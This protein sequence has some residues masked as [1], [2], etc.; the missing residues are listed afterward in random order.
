MNSKRK[1][2]IIITM[3]VF[4]FIFLRVMNTLYYNELSKDG[5]SKEVE[6]TVEIN[7]DGEVNV[8]KDK[9]ETISNF[10]DED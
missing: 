7:N 8:D 2:L 10:I 4:A 9:T 6:Y 1:F 3:F 5:F